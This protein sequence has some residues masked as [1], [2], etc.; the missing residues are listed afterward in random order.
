MPR[1]NDPS[2]TEEPLLDFTSGYVLRSLDDLPKQG[3]KEPWK[4]RQNY[5][6]TCGTAPRRARRRHDA[7]L[8]RRRQGFPRIAPRLCGR[9]G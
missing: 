9:P 1:V 5:P 7:V 6:S 3:S 4:L 8:P 2:V